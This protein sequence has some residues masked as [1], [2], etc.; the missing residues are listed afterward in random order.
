LNIVFLFISCI[1]KLQNVDNYKNKDIWFCVFNPAAGTKD[2]EKVRDKIEFELYKNN[3]EFE[4]YFTKHKGDAISV[5]IDKIME[6][7]TKFIAAGGDGTVHE[8]VNAFFLQDFVPTDRI[9]LAVIP[10][11]TGNDWAKHHKLPLDISKAIDLITKDATDLQD[12]GI[13]QYYKGN[14][15]KTEYF[16]NVAGMA[17]DAFVVKKLEQ[18]KSKPNKFIYILSVLSYLFQYKLQKAKVRL[19]DR[20]FVNKFYTINIGICKYSGG[21]MS[22]VPHAVHNDGKFAVTLAGN[23]SKL[24]VVLNTYRFYNETLTEHPKIDA[25]YS[26]NIEVQSLNNNPVLLELDGELAGETPVTFDIIKKGLRFVVSDN[27]KI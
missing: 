23:I 9:T 4:L 18:R 26:K 8:V 17:Y 6:G 15:K 24:D 1:S 22:L 16:N 7:F 14:K 3:I 10:T 5:V 11:G 20:E 19:N 21:G 13:A 12:I 2:I 25:F 27:S